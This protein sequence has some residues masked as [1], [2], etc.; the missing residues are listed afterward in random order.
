LTNFGD[1]GLIELTK[2]IMSSIFTKII[3]GEIPCYK[4]YE[5]DKIFAFL[6]AF[7]MELGHTLIVTKK[8]IDNWLNV[9]YEDY[10]AIHNIAQKIG[11]AISDSISN[12]SGFERI[13]QMVDGRA[14]PHFHL[15]LVPLHHGQEI[16]HNTELRKSFTSG[17]MTAVQ[18]KIIQNLKF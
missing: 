5:D 14:V 18:N 3:K 12:V 17:Q 8:E 16:T 2:K 1:W 15:H 9:P 13:G 11:E 4:I 7:P 10:Q 6:D